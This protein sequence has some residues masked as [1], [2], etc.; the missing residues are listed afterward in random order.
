MGEV[1]L[2]GRFVVASAEQVEKAYE[3]T[4]RSL[5]L[6][7]SNEKVYLW[8]KQQAIVWIPDEPPAKP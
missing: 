5:G 7:R 1:E 6:L 3:L 4:A 2:K 8:P